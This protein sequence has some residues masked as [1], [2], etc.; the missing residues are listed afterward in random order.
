MYVASKRSQGGTET[1][2]G[3]LWAVVRVWYPLYPMSVPTAITMLVRFDQF[4]KVR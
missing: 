2:A 4:D 1:E 3:W